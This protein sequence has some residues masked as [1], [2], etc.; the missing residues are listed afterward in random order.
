MRQFFTGM[1]LTLAIVG[2]GLGTYYYGLRQTGEQKKEDILNAPLFTITPQPPAS[3]IPQQTTQQTLEAVLTRVADSIKNR[4]YA[5]LSPLMAENVEVT[6]AQSTCC[7]TI[8]KDQALSKLTALNSATPPWDFT[9]GSSTSAQLSEK[10]PT[11]FKNMFTGIAGNKF[12]VAFGFT[13]TLL[14]QQIFIT[15]DYDLILS[16]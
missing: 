7:G 9:I 6:I 8:T 12:A 3:P 5:E 1:A 2:L 4:S 11:H 13:Q 15:P 10:D 14:I 16:Q